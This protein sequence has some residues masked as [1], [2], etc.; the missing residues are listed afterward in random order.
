[1]FELFNRE[2]NIL[3]PLED[4]VA[5]VTGASRGI[6]AATAILFAQAGANVAI[7]YHISEEAASKV[8]RPGQNYYLFKIRDGSPLFSKA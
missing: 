4:K 2:G 8:L 6:G 5:I 3:K 1:M 7:N